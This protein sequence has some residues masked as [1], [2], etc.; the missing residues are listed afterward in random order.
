MLMFYRKL[1]HFS[2]KCESY[3]HF[4][5]QSSDI[6]DLNL[7]QCFAHTKFGCMGSSLVTH[8]EP[9]SHCHHGCSY[10]YATCYPHRTSLLMSPD[11][12][13]QTI[14]KT[15]IRKAT[16][17]MA[18]YK[19][20]QKTQSVP[21]LPPELHFSISTDFLQ[22]DVLIQSRSLLI[23]QTW[24]Q[25]GLLVSMV[26]KGVPMTSDLETR[27]LSIVEQYH[28]QI[29]F[30][31]T[32][33]SIDPKLQHLAEPGAP[34]PD[35]RLNFLSKII[36]T[37]VSRVS[38][39]INPLIPEF[40]DSDGLLRELID[41]VASMNVKRLTVS[42][43]YGSSRIFIHMNKIPELYRVK[44]YFIPDTYK[45]SG[46]APKFHVKKDIR[47][48]TTEWVKQYASS[49]GIIATSCGCD[50]QDLYPEDKCGISWRSGTW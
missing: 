17:M 41:R 44:T 15:T 49:K 18:R 28:Q 31:C 23:I 42:Y 26:T 5:A 29:S 16:Q 27:F 40:N 21:L 43:M 24:L 33:A 45:L 19:R 38:L 7:N 32:C 46:G 50:N 22:P 30:Q 13:E 8:F 1:I 14:I 12:S 47:Q 10:C 37:G 3:I 39:R 9:S 6:E 11:Y 36:K 4:M 48:K 34:S 35:T 20:S 25:K 2:I